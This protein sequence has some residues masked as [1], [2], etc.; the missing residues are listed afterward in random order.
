MPT[1]SKSLVLV[2]LVGVITAPL[3]AQGLRLDRPSHDR[4]AGC[5]EDGHVPAPGP[6]SHSC[7]QVGHHPAILQQIST[8][9]SSLQVSAQVVSSQDAPVVAAF[10]PFQSYVVVSGGPPVMSPLRV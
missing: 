2:L 7:C 5:H 8:S 6:T 9:R 3:A 1:I 4:P 10:H